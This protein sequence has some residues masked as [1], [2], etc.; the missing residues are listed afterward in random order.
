MR[1]GQPQRRADE[2]RHHRRREAES[3][4]DGLSLLVDGIG[5]KDGAE[6]VA[7]RKIDGPND[8]RDEEAR[9]RTEDQESNCDCF[10]T[11]AA[12]VTF[13]PTVR[14]ILLLLGVGRYA[15]GN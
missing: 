10:T 12:T 11:A 13:N 8:N 3:A 5:V 9:D 6:D 2:H 7:K 15:C 4:H 14:R 1:A